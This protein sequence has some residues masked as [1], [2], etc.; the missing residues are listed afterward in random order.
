MLLKDA[1]AQEQFLVL[2]LEEAR[3]QKMAMIKAARKITEHEGVTVAP[4]G[5]LP[6]DAETQAKLTAVYV[7]ALNDPTYTK[8]WK[9][10]PTTWV[11]L[12]A[13]TIIA[14]G[15][16]VEAHVQAQF[17]KEQVLTNQVVNATTVEEIEA[18]NW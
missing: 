15:D 3:A 8:N 4:F 16:A 9:V 13:P 1:I 10:G 11:D 18:L 5:L 12:N 2:P 6:T 17:D 7:K 14:I